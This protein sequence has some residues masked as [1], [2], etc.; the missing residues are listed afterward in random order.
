MLFDFYCRIYKR[1][2]KVPLDTIV[3]IKWTN[4]TVHI[5]GILTRFI[6]LLG[7]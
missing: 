1:K 5:V 7:Y 2:E 6:T 4:F 3:R